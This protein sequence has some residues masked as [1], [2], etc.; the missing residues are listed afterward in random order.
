MRRRR[1]RDVAFTALTCRDIAVRETERLAVGGFPNQTRTRY[2]YIY[3]YLCLHSGHYFD[4]RRNFWGI[5][6]KDKSELH[7][8]IS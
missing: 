2:V 4:R 3:I 8:V 5:G 1:H 7:T 6:R